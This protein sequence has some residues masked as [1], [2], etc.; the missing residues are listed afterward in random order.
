LVEGNKNL[1]Y[2]YFESKDK[3]FDSVFETHVALGLDRVPFTAA[4]PVGAGR[5]RGSIR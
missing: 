2:V 4:V 3:L 1:L 5:G